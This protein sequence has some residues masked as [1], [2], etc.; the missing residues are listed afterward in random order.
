[1]VRYTQIGTVLSLFPFIKK[2]PQG[3]SGTP[4]ILAGTT[5]KETISNRA[6]MLITFVVLLICSKLWILGCQV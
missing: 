3:Q 4:V 6:G 1:M 5:D 2:V